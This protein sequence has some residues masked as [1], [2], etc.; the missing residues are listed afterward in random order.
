[1]MLFKEERQPCNYGIIIVGKCYDFR[2]SKVREI[3]WTGRTWSADIADVKLCLSPEVFEKT[4]AKAK[5]DLVKRGQTDYIRL[6]YNIGTVSDVYTLPNFEEAK[7]MLE[8]RKYVGGK[9]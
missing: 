8:K 2:D 7:K 3:Y 9:M 6:S 1:M 5:E 4:V